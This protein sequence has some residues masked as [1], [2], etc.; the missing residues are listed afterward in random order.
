MPCLLDSSHTFEKEGVNKNV[1][2]ADT[3]KI[4]AKRQRRAR[5]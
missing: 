3:I 1:D 2:A 4:D 5:T